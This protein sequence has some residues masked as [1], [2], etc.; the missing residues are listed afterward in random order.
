MRLALEHNDPAPIHHQLALGDE[1]FACVALYPLGDSLG[2]SLQRSGSPERSDACSGLEGELQPPGALGALFEAEPPIDRVK[3]LAR[4]LL[5]TD[6]QM[7]ADFRSGGVVSK[8]IPG[9]HPSPL[10]VAPGTTRLTQYREMRQ[11]AVDLARP[12]ALKSPEPVGLRGFQVDGA[13]WLSNSD[14]AILADDMGLGKTVQAIHALRV[15]FNEGLVETALIVCPKSLLTNWETEMTRWA[16]ELTRCRVV[17]SASTRDPIWSVIWGKVHIALTNYEQ[18]RTVPLALRNETIGVVIADE[19]HRTRNNRSLITKG[20]RSLKWDHF[21]ALTGTPFERDSADL[22]TLLATLEPTRFSVSDRSLHISSLRAQARPYVLRR[23]KADVLKDLPDVLETKE[24]LELTPSQLRAYRNTARM[25]SSRSASSVLKVINELRT[26]CDYDATSQSSSKADRI[27]EILQDIRAQGEKAVV[28]SYLL[29]PLDMLG[30]RLATIWGERGYLDLRGDMTPE[31]R[32]RSLDE[33]SGNASVSALLCSSRVGGEGLTLTAA[34]HVLFFNEWWNPSAN[35]QA[36][37]RVVRIGQ[38][39]VVQIYKFMC[40]GTVEEVLDE[41]L[42]SKTRT[43]AK[44]IDKL[45]DAADAYS[46]LGPILSE[47]SAKVF[48]PP[49][50]H[51]PVRKSSATHLHDVAR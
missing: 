47:L 37:D 16:P 5:D 1:L 27:I 2:V 43:M 13:K 31:Q 33:F 49:D 9:A 48:A 12:L 10:T 42:Q 22:A 18:L 41:V 7:M 20:I 32:D 36:R 14:K 21:W 30:T 3:S 8:R 51:G 24:V 40:K 17:P 6:G 25:P 26:I 46:E 11:A 50:N 34:N 45:A 38:K 35:A 29:G 19:A 15:L 39:R 28:F 23:M 4:R 44:L